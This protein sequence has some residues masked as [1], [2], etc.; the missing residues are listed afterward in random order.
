MF[1]GRMA[2]SCAL[3]AN[4]LRRSRSSHPHSREA[5]TCQS[6]NGRNSAPIKSSSKPA[7]A[8]PGAAAGEARSSHFAMG[9]IPAQASIRSYSQRSGPRPHSF[10]AARIPAIPPTATARIC[11]SN[12]GHA[13]IMRFTLYGPRPYCYEGMTPRRGQGRGGRCA[14][15][16]RG[17]GGQRLQWLI[18]CNS[19]STGSRSV[20]STV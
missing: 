3:P 6:R 1:Q 15:P 9:H 16:C 17:E 10:A 11:C 19:S 8:M 20:R 5:K 13:S 4:W 18:F 14:S 2:L 7:D 12:L